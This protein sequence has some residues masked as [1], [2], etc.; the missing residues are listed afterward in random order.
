MP[1]HLSNR[2]A[3]VAAEERLR[4]NF[5]KTME[6][7]DACFTLKAAYLKQ[8]YPQESD[9]EIAR[10]IYRGI[11]KRKQAQWTFRDKSLKP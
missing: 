6:L 7:I 1:E 3:A 9:R 11:L 5:L 10:R 4:K 8:R 2:E